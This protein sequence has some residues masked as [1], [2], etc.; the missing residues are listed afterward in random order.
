MVAWMTVAS[1]GFAFTRSRPVE[2]QSSPGV[3]RGFCGRCGTSLTYVNV[4]DVGTVDVTLASLDAP[5]EVRPSAHTWMHDALAWD[6]PGD[7]LPHFERF[8]DPP[9]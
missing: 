8:R 4:N 2:H 5:N 7:G 3:T 9:S 1:E 6:R